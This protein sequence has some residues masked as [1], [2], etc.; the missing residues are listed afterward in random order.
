MHRCLEQMG[1]MMFG[2]NIYLSVVLASS[3]L[4]W[5]ESILTGW[6]NSQGG[7]L[8]LLSPFGEWEQVFR[9]MRAVHRKPFPLFAPFQVLIAQ[10]HQHTQVAY[11]GVG[12]SATLRFHDLCVFVCMYLPGTFSCTWQAWLQDLLSQLHTP[13]Q[14]WGKQMAPFTSCSWGCSDLPWQPHSVKWP[15][16]PWG[17]TEK[18]ED[19][20]VLMTFTEGLNSTVGPRLFSSYGSS[21]FPFGV[22][23]FFFLTPVKESW[24]GVPYTTCCTAL[25]TWEKKVAPSHSGSGRH[26]TMTHGQTLCKSFHFILGC[27]LQIT[28][29]TNIPVDIEN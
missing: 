11:F 7:D 23:I 28:Q 20:Q 2:G 17:W 5:Q 25:P 10:N 19:N 15:N 6:W 18:M 1:S 8:W 26:R 12:Y 14:W 24:W 9:E 27:K 4:L 29:L 13:W 21:I 3:S 16:C 22:G